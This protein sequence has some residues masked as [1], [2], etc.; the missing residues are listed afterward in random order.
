M[1]SGISRTTLQATL[2]KCLESEL[3]SNPTDEQRAAYQKIQDLITYIST[4]KNTN[5]AQSYSL[6]GVQVNPAK[7]KTDELGLEVF[8]QVFGIRSPFPSIIKMM[9]GNYI[10][11]ET[12]IFSPVNTPY[13]DLSVKPFGS[14]DVNFTDPTVLKSYLGEKCQSEAHLASALRIAKRTYQVDRRGIGDQEFGYAFPLYPEVQAYAMEFLN[15]DHPKKGKKIAIE[16]GGASGENA[17]LLG[18]YRRR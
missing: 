8:Q 11:K 16:M 6:S 1:S 3:Y 18:V 7:S 5:G 15:E 9:I 10:P 14:F 12:Q 2:P 4:L 13:R 17:I